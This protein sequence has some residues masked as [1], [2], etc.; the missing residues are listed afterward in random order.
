MS[1]VTGERC[2]CGEPFAVE[3]ADLREHEY[4]RIHDLKPIEHCEGCGRDL[5]EV[6]EERAEQR[7]EYFESYYGED[8]YGVRC[9]GVK[10]GGDR[11]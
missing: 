3:I 8:P 1:V 4:L 10:Y 2:Y 7:Q 6:D 5:V 9:G 11:A